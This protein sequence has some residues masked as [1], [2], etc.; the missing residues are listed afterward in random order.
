[1][2]V[3]DLKVATLA[4]F[5]P[6]SV[7]KFGALENCNAEIRDFKGENVSSDTTIEDLYQTSKLK[8]L[9]AYLYS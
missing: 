9:K 2:T 6:N 7:S 8:T 5:F 3:N 4:K 1:M